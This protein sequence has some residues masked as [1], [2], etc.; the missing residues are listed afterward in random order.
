MAA[1]EGPLVHDA[2]FSRNHFVAEPDGDVDDLLGFRH[3]R[4]DFE[5]DAAFG[6]VESAAYCLQIHFSRGA[7]MRDGNEIEGFE[8]FSSLGRD[9]AAHLPQPP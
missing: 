9:L 1:F 7:G 3:W 4:G 5:E 2:A 8:T 6:K